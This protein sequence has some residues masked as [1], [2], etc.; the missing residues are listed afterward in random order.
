M[1]DN[2]LLYKKMSLEELV[3]LAQKEDFK[4]LGEL[5]RKVQK[6]VYGG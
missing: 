2:K 6:D 4:A 1:P 3:V 5:I